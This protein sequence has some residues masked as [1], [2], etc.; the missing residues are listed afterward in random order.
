[1]KDQD[2]A[3]PVATSGEGIEEEGAG[4][5][6]QTE[7]VD[8]EAPADGAEA[9][10]QNEGVAVDDG[11]TTLAPPSTPPRVRTGERERRRDRLEPTCQLS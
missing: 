10:T 3:T 6:L 8:V 5:P 7:G 1:M 2:D 4:A 9:L 11:Q